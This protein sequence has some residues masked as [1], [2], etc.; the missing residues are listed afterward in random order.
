MTRISFKDKLLKSDGMSVSEVK[1]P[2]YNMNDQ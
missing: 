1:G 2:L